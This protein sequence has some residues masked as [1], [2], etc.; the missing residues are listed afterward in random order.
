MFGFN[1]LWIP[2]T[3]GKGTKPITNL[4]TDLLLCSAWR[5]VLYARR[6]FL[7]DRLRQPHRVTHLLLHLLR[8]HRLHRAEST[9]WCVFSWLPKRIIVNGRFLDA[10]TSLSLSKIIQHTWNISQ[11]TEPDSKLFQNS[12]AK[13]FCRVFRR[14]SRNGLMESCT[15]CYCH[16][17]GPL[18]WP[19]DPPDPGP[20]LTLTWHDDHVLHCHVIWWRSVLVFSHHY[21]EL[22]AVLLQWRRCTAELQWHTS[23]SEHLEHGGRQQ[24][25]ERKKTRWLCRDVVSW[26]AGVFTET[27]QV[28][29][30]C[31][32]SWS[33]FSATVISVPKQNAA[34][35]RWNAWREKN[36]RFATEHYI[37]AIQFEGVPTYH[38]PADYLNLILTFTQGVIPVRR[39]KF[40]LRLLKGRLE[41]DLE[42]DRLL[43]KHM[44]YEIERLH[45]GDDVTF[46]DVLRWASLQL[47]VFH[48]KLRY[49]AWTV[50][51]AFVYHLSEMSLCLNKS[52]WQTVIYW[53]NMFSLWRQKIVQMN[54]HLLRHKLRSKMFAQ[55]PSDFLVFM[56]FY[57]FTLVCCEKQNLFFYLSWIRGMPPNSAAWPLPLLVPRLPWRLSSVLQTWLFQYA[58]VPVCGHQEV[59]AAGGA[60]GSGGAGVHHRG[61]SREADDPQLAWQMP[62]ADSS[63]VFKCFSKHER[64]MIWSRAK[65][66]R[67]VLWGNCKLTCWNHIA[68][69]ERQKKIWKCDTALS[70]LLLRENLHWIASARHLHIFNSNR[71][72]SSW[73]CAFFCGEKQKQIY[74][75]QIIL[76]SHWGCSI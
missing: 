9:C 3:D 35:M 28:R 74:A 56:R 30:V 33:Y 45:N 70:V 68:W 71:L 41:V 20:P 17:V 31:L 10:A 39:V 62:Q 4:Q 54:L 40:V 59:A 16:H 12:F 18:P 7:G 63:G 60:A 49:K 37:T 47:L 11:S 25:G 65:G 76:F 44:C 26:C 58:G 32:G 38:L 66:T 67:A 51:G 42:K 64:F 52:N 29:V 21:G 43:F 27:G 72:M 19:W 14:R 13:E 73:I 48:F 23:V 75:F 15:C 34:F 6:E 53:R 5:A 1:F 55:N 8:H 2:W 61:G 22:L 50:L 46:H 36:F 57:S 24:K 69:G